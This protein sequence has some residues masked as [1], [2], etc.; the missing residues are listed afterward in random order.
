MNENIEIWK[1]VV[2]F[3]DYKVSN[4]GNVKSFKK[5]KEKIL[6]PVVNGRGY[7]S[8]CLRKDKIAYTKRVHVIVCESFLN[9]FAN[10]S[11]EKSID[12]I[13][14]NKLNNN[15]NNLQIISHRDNIVKS[16]TNKN[17][18]TGVK[19]YGN[20]FCAYISINNKYKHLGIFN[21][22]LDAHNRY[23]Q[24]VLMLNK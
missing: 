24:E 13:D 1:E 16:V 23:K 17:G 22:A 2:N 15:L 11:T 10:G 21:T 12:H 19:K 14:N 8:V 3:N 6:K 9:H 5:G 4:Y 7:L 18:F 20:K